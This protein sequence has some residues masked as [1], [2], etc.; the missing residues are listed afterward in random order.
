MNMKTILCK[1]RIVG[2]IFLVFSIIVYII[3]DS[4]P[5]SLID[6]FGSSLYPQ[7]LA[8]LI[9]L[10]SI[11]LIITA[12][13]SP[14]EQAQIPAAAA[15]GR[16][17][18][19]VGFTILALF[20]YYLLFRPLGFFLSTIAFLMAFCLYFDRKQPMAERAKH[21]IVFAV[22]FSAV[23][24]FLFAKLLGVLLPTLFLGR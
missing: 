17:F 19:G 10:C 21:G 5:V 2:L 1:D 11:A 12:K 20:C 6:K 18:R 22:L 4:F 13:P 16:D 8:I 24:Y 14:E 9:G 23:L 7:I 15:K 3:A